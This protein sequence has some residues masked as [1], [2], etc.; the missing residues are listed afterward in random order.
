MARE[1]VE[2]MG[3]PAR[4]AARRLGVAPSAISQYL[5]GKRLGNVVPLNADPEMARKVARRVAHQVLKV[6]SGED[7]TSPLLLRAAADLAS[8]PHG[9]AGTASPSR[10]GQPSRQTRAMV[11]QLRRRIASEQSAVADCM[12]LAQRARDELTRAL[13]RQIA[14]DSLRHAEIAASLASFLDRGT[15]ETMVSGISAGDVRDLIAREQ[16]AER[17]T[18]REPGAEFGGV[19][20]ILW[21]SVAADERK[22]DSLL[23]DLLAECVAAGSFPPAP[24]VRRGRAARS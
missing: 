2:E 19:M 11:R 14:S 10:V 4:E 5:S 21:L 16:A 20:R 8:G 18:A 9:P 1:L 13:F 24:A 7:S 15:S 23:K 6:P 22:H 17:T 12:R 3:V